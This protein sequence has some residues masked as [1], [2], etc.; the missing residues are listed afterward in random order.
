DARL[1]AARRDAPPVVAAARDDV[2][3][4]ARGWTVLR[5]PE[6]P[7]LGIPGQ[8]LGVAVAVAPDGRYRIGSGHER[9][10]LRH[11]SIVVHAVD[12][13]HRARQVL[14]V[15][16]DA[17]FADREEQVPLAIEDEP[18]AEMRAVGR[19]E[20]WRRAENDLL[21]DPFVAAVD[22]PSNDR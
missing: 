13:A 15:L 20:V 10:V 22:T 5:F 1:A 3:F 2:D 14:R 17:A 8:P 21:I 11:R 19:V 16:H 7:G 6:L 4:I 9:I 18:G 12:L